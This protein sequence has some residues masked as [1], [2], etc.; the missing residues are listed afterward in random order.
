[1]A[2]SSKTS[3]ST[4]RALL[5]ALTPAAALAVAVLSAGAQEVRVEVVKHAD[6]Q[7][8]RG[9]LVT[10]IPERESQPIGRFSDADG[11]VAFTTPRRGGYRV[12]AEKVGY[13]TWSSV[14]LVP[15]SAPTR[16]RAGMKPR[17]LR[18]PPVAGRGETHCSNFTEQATAASDMWGEI[19][20]ALA[21]NSVTESQGLAPLDIERYDRTTDANGTVISEHT[22]RRRGNSIRPYNIIELP[23]AA[24]GPSALA[25]L[26]VP[27]AGTLLSDDFINTHCFTAVRG[28]GPQ[29]GL[30][31]L[32]L[33][34]AKLGNKPDLSGVLWLDPTTYSLRHFIFDYVNIPVSLRAGR[35]NGRVDY[36]QLASGEW[37][38]A[39]W[40]LK[41]P[42]GAKGAAP[43]KSAITGYHEIGGFARST[44]S[45]VLAVPAAGVSAGAASGFTRISGSVLDGTTD[46]PL[47]GV[48]VS[49]FSGSHKTTTNLGGGYEL[50]VDGAVAD[51]L[52]FEHPRLRLLRVQQVLPVS[53]VSGG[54]AQ[55]S[56]VIPNF[57]A[58]RQA[59]CPGSG[60]RL[61]PTGLAIGYVRDQGGN[62]VADAQVAATWQLLW[63]EEKGRLVATNQ[64]R[65]V[66][67]RTNADGAYLVCGFTRDAPVALGVITDGRLRVEDR[68]SVPRNLII[69]H[70]FRI[71]SR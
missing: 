47:S 28:T 45:H 62:P 59:L 18:L 7:P 55:V 19:R 63:I 65:R 6:G 43:G 33:K 36:E 56:I 2:F 26:S 53:V 46:K 23:A 27:E 5:R 8:I 42:R 20:K 15:A 37:I 16:V 69:E 38:V 49:T 3:A 66:D 60:S 51:S 32:E 44:G 1:M 40:Q 34:P 61:K 30:L 4:R 14:V 41:I 39:R 54:Q 57:T 22:E 21:A 64:Q 67:V 70:D 31:G 58:L 12:R 11:R 24:S 35:A 52:V 50:L 17:S 71:Q 68:V 25:T 9:A 10:V 48:E 13:D 29:N